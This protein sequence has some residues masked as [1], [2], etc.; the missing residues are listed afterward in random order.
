MKVRPTKWPEIPRNEVFFF[1]FEVI[2]SAEFAAENL[3]LGQE[4]C[5]DNAM[6]WKSF[7]ITAGL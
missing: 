3:R 5:R 2:D 4:N 1:F 7:P 6:F